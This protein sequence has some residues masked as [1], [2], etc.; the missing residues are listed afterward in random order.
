MDKFSD[1]ESK[2]YEKITIRAITAMFEELHKAVT[3]LLAKDGEGI[4]VNGGFLM[5][6]IG[7]SL[8]AWC[9]RLEESS[10]LEPGILVG[11]LSTGI[12]TEIM[13]RLEFI[14]SAEMR[15]DGDDTDETEKFLD[16]FDIPFKVGKA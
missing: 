16:E 15:E 5:A 10:D 8:T 7:A 12:A 1:E 6:N 2:A 9:A 4:S 13:A 11:A 3:E 14:D